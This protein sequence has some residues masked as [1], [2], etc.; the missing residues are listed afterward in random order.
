MRPLFSLVCSL[1]HN[2]LTS[3]SL[4]QDCCEYW[5][6]PLWPL[7]N[8]VQIMPAWPSLVAEAYQTVFSP[9]EGTGNPGLSSP[10][11]FMSAHSTIETGHI[12][13]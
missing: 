1:M 4:E 8:W 10:C 7:S 12:A 6:V 11:L 5:Q 2:C 9:Y 13:G 3:L